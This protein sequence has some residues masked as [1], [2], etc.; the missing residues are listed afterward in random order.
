VNIGPRSFFKWSALRSV[1]TATTSG[2]YSPVWPSRSVNKRLFIMF[3]LFLTDRKFQLNSA[4]FMMAMYISKKNYLAC[5]GACRS[6]AS[7]FFHR[8][9]EARKRNCSC[10]GLTKFQLKKLLASS[11]SAMET[12]K[13]SFVVCVFYVISELLM[14][15][16]IL[17]YKQCYHFRSL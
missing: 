10:S 16:A 2:Q 6:V 9:C 17:V 12:Q 11:K 14:L 8:R 13:F 7:Q 4:F 1:R 5:L 15:A 3:K